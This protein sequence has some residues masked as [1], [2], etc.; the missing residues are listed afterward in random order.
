MD[1]GRRK[2]LE[3]VPTRKLLASIK[4]DMRKLA[5][6]AASTAKPKRK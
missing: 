1:K 2:L 3:A 4:Q 6:K 5:K